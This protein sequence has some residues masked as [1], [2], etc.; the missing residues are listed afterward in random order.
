MIISCNL[1]FICDNY[2]YF[3]LQS[4]IY[5][6]LFLPQRMLHAEVMDRGLSFG[7]KM[8]LLTLKVSLWVL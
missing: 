1:F 3:T 8:S 2:L 4:T 7:H 6:H 5:N